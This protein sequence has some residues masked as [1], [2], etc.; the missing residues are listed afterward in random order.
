MRIVGHIVFQGSY[1]R[2]QD[3]DIVGD[4]KN[5]EPGILGFDA[6]HIDVLYCEVSDC[7]AAESILRIPIH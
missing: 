6:H 1:I 2:I 4:S 5:D 7:R 3:L